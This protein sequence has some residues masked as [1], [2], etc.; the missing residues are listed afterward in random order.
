LSG[1]DRPDTL[2]IRGDLA[3]LETDFSDA[4]AAAR[5]SLDIVERRTR[6]VGAEAPDT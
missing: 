2:T 4:Q 1:P 6:L 5:I 3:S